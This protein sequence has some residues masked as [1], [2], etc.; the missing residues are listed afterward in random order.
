[1]PRNQGAGTAAHKASHHT[2]PR[3][4]RDAAWGRPGDDDGALDGSRARSSPSTSSSSSSSS[5]PS[6]CTASAAVNACLPPAHFAVADWQSTGSGAAPWGSSELAASTAGS[7]ASLSTAATGAARATRGLAVAAASAGSDPASHPAQA[8]NAP[9]T[10]P[11]PLNPSSLPG[12]Q[13]AL[14]R[15]GGGLGLRLPQRRGGAG[16]SRAAPVGAGCGRRRHELLAGSAATGAAWEGPRDVRE[17]AGQ[18]ENRTHLSQGGRRR[19]IERMAPR[20]SSGRC[21]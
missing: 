2:H 17:R 18:Q 9:R 4:S 7:S 5:P 19:V 11:G 12:A 10:T 13:R 21:R 3:R 8:P 14:S 1:M 16:N 15:S 20:A 6:T